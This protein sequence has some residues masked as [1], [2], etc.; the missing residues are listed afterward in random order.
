[1]KRSTGLKIFF[2]LLLLSPLLASQKETLSEMVG[3]L[4]K[5]EIDRCKGDIDIDKVIE[6]IRKATKGEKAPLSKEEYQLLINKIIEH[7][8]AEKEKESLRLATDFFQKNKKNRGVVEIVA[9]KL[10]YEIISKGFGEIVDQYHTPLISIKGLLPDNTIF[11]P[12]REY[13]APLNE[14]PQGLKLAILG[15][16]E[17]ERRKIYVHPDFAPKIFDSLTPKSLLIYEVEL[18]KNDKSKI[19]SVNNNLA[20]DSAAHR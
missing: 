10:Q 4:I 20:V 16:K 15:M 8:L 6:G 9:Q 7:N 3:Y 14:L 11:L 13:I 12:E 18:L 17:K 5:E 1:M 2:F 19:N